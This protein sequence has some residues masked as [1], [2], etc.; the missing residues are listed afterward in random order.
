MA[1]SG[2]GKAP[3]IERVRRKRTEREREGGCPSVLGQTFLSLFLV[4]VT[5]HCS[6]SKSKKC[7]ERTD[8]VVAN[9]EDPLT[10]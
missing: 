8:R 7:R 9:L 4:T 2:H 5:P 6:T 3:R 10:L 1:S